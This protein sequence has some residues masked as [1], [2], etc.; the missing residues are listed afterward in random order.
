MEFFSW[1]RK[2]QIGGDIIRVLVNQEQK[3]LEEFRFRG[4]K[5]FQVISN[6][7]RTP[8]LYAPFLDSFFPGEQSKKI[9]YDEDY[10]LSYVTPYRMA[11]KIT[12]WILSFCN[13]KSAIDLTAGLGGNVLGFARNKSI[14]R[15][16]GVEY[17]SNRF[18]F[19]KH[20]VELYPEKKKITLYNENCIDF[21]ERDFPE[22]SFVYMDPPWG[23]VSQFL[24]VF[25]YFQLSKFQP[26]KQRRN[27]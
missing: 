18:H 14:E 4:K 11:D 26:F 22:H 9:Q 16:I 23:G 2:N 21:I 6:I 10:S 13:A 24:S 7:P 12:N 3:E 1:C 8:K 19:L 17:D 25:F 20:N 5:V 27:I 15:V